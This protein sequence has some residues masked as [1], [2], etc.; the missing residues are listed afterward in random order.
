MWTVRCYAM[1]LYNNS[2]VAVKE[3]IGNFDIIKFPGG[4]VK[5]GEGLINA[6]KREVEEE[7]G[8]V[9]G[10]PWQ[11]VYVNHF[12]VPSA[13]RKDKEV[14]AVYY[15]FEVNNQIID[16][17]GAEKIRDVKFAFS[18]SKSVLLVP[19]LPEMV[20]LFLIPTDRMAFIN[21]LKMVRQ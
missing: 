13:F 5:Q 10:S 2:V 14:I 6:V 11:L 15:A 3:K 9:I 19:L 7:L 16:E 8:I 21:L 1:I 12:F 17:L 20:E 18:V 4:G